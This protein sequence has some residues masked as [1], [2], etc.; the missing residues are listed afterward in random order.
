LKLNSSREFG[1]T[2]CRKKNTICGL[3]LSFSIFAAQNAFPEGESREIGRYQVVPATI[4]VVAL[5][6]DEKGNRRA[7]SERVPT[8]IRIDTTT[9]K[10][11][12]L[13]AVVKDKAETFWSP[14]SDS[15]PV[16]KLT[17]QASI[18]MRRAS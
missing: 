4:E 2:V 8:L 11:W 18:A 16:Q 7:A 12:Q 13:N 10:T 6:K 9:G 14:I 15:P 1:K 17:K 5:G 3:V